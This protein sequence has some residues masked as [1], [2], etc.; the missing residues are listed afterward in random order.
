MSDLGD[1]KE[2]V[3]NFAFLFFAF[4]GFIASLISVLQYF[5][6]GDGS[7]L[8]V[9]AYSQD[10]RVPLYAGAGMRS[11]ERG[12][13]Y[14][15]K[16]RSEACDEVAIPGLASLSY[17]QLAELELDTEAYEAAL[18]CRDLIDVEYAARFSGNESGQFS[19]LITYEIVNRGAQVA[20][21]IRISD[22]DVIA[23]EYRRGQKFQQLSKADKEEFYK[24]PELNP[25]ESMTVLIWAGSPT[26]SQRFI[27]REDLPSITYSGPE[28]QFSI[29]RRVSGVWSDLGGFLDD[30]PL[31][32]LI[33]LMLAAS[34]VILFGVVFVFSVID[35]II[36]GKPFSSIFIAEKNETEEPTFTQTGG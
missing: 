11:G 13:S 34:I 4:V 12:R 5:R 24:L 21:E 7:Y 10:F 18:T 16:L 6:P 30:T 31:P 27:D 1:K 36:N 15:S 33:V 25:Q 2:R 8:E 32:I 22:E 26:F 29:S 9:H 23:A 28:I 3:K 20:R 14:A 35:V 17:A 19:S